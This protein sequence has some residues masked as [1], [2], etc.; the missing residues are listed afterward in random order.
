MFSDIT[1]ELLARD[2]QLSMRV[3]RDRACDESYGHLVSTAQSSATSRLV[4][5]PL[6]KLG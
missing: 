3:M 5:T 6:G 2:P 4:N 1:P